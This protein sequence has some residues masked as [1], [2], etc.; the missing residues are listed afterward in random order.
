MSFFFDQAEAD[1]TLAEL[2]A[3]ATKANAATE[4]ILATT[5]ASLALCQK[6]HPDVKVGGVTI[7]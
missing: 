6:N 7:A 2:D 4:E 5:E 3:K 1:A